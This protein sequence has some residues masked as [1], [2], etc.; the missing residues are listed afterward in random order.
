M[1]DKYGPN[2]MS[3]TSPQ[4][5]HSYFQD[6]PTP[7]FVN[8]ARLHAEH[9]RIMPQFFEDVANNELPLYSWLDPQYSED[10]FEPATDQHPDHDVTMGEKLLKKIYESLRASDRWQDT[11]LI[12]YYDEHGGFFDHVPPPNCPNPDGINS[13]HISPPFAFQRLGVRI[14][15][16]LVSP[17]IKKGTVGHKP[18]PDQP[19][20]CHSSL[21]HTMREQF[22]PA[23]PPLTKR[24]DWAL[25]FDDLIN[26]DEMREDCP[27][28][29]PDVPVGEHGV[30]VLRDWIPGQQP[31]HAYQESILRMAARM[32]HRD[33]EVEDHMHNQQAM[34]RFLKTCM[35]QWM[36]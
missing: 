1:I 33:E 16:V 36:A 2:N 4:K 27:M 18:A 11:L 29:L 13:T 5:W 25:T 14:P 21:I 35:K 30:S 15:V 28:T 17:W 9:A 7:G 6:A 22:A 8:Y 23:S 3:N 34:H 12:V 26:L 20:Y 32:C 19:Q 10:V 24:E 31:L